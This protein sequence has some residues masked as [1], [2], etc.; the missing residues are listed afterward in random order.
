[1]AKIKNGVFFFYFYKKNKK[2]PDIQKP[3][4]KHQTKK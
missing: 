4:L 1:M 2:R 3:Q